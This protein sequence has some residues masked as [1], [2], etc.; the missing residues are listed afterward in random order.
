MIS[1][2][3]FSLTSR[4]SFRVISASHGPTR[5]TVSIVA[6]RSAVSFRVKELGI[7]MV[8]FEVPSSDSLFTSI[9]PIRPLF[10]SSRK[11]RSKRS[12]SV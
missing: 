10:C 3:F 7:L 8:P 6:A 1:L 4:I 9:L 2:R 5:D 11:S 12:P